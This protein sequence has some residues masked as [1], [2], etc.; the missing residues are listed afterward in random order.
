MVIYTPRLCNDV[1][2]LP[3]RNNKAHPITCQEI[4]SPD[5]IEAWKTRK[6]FEAANNLLLHHRQAET[7]PTSGDNLNNIIIGGIPIGAQTHVGREGRR[8]TSGAVTGGPA[9][10]HGNTA[11]D[12]TSAEASVV[13]AQR[14]PKSRG[15]KIKRLSDEELKKLGIDPRT[16]EELRNELMGLAGDKGWRLEVVEIENAPGAAGDDGEG[17]RQIRGIIDSD[18]SDSDSIGLEKVGGKRKKDGEKRNDRAGEKE[19]PL[20]GGDVPDGNEGT[21]E[22]YVEDL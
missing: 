13:L 22:E 14:A 4:L 17:I 8:I 2:F 1:A 18:E 7:K 3:P 19:V 20:T 12:A 15:G 5:Q 11:D 10:S 21:E 6:S 9:N 16:V